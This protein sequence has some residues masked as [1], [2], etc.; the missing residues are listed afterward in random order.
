MIFRFAPLSAG[1][2]N[3]LGCGIF[4]LFNTK[5]E[6]LKRERQL[7]GWSHKKKKNLIKFGKG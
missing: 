4:I 6:A 7:K 3:N 5:Q 1:L 2:I